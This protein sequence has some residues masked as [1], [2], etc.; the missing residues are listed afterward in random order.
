VA[1]AVVALIVT[2][3]ELSPTSSELP[4][5]VWL[6]AITAIMFGYLAQ[7]F[8]R[9]WRNGKFWA[10]YLL[11][12]ILHISVWQVALSHRESPFVFAATV[13]VGV[14]FVLLSMIIEKVAGSASNGYR[15]FRK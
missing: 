9:S 8:R 1:F 7:A 11:L 14:E 3:A 6:A 4:P 15:F 12:L 13:S 5:W 10:V 2:Y